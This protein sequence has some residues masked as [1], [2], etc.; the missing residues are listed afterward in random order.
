MYTTACRYTGLLGIVHYKLQSRNK[1][2]TVEVLPEELF[3][4]S[5]FLNGAMQNSDYKRDVVATFLFLVHLLAISRN[6]HAL[7]AKF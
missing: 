3:Y 1:L 7:H 5:F 2:L 4:F 6:E